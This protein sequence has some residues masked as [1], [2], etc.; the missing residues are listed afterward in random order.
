MKVRKTR[1]G[2]VASAWVGQLTL[3]GYGNCEKTAAKDL[4]KQI[5]TQTA[6]LNKANEIVIDYIKNAN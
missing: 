2:Y 3:N 1:Y 4:L 5:Q 6:E